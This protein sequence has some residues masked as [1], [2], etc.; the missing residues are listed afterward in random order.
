MRA[1]GL[2]IAGLAAFLIGVGGLFVASRV[3]AAPLSGTARGFGYGGMTGMSGMAG[4]M[5]GP[6]AANA[7]PIGVERA[8]TTA[9]NYVTGSGNR[10]LKLDEVMEF[11]GNYY[12]QVVEQDTGMHAFEMLVDKY[13]GAVFP[14]MGPNMVWNVKYGMMRGMMGRWSLGWSQTTS[15]PI[16]PTRA[17]DLARQYLKTQGLR[18]DVD[19]PDE[20]YGYYTLHTLRDGEIEGM[21]SVNGYSGEIWYHTW[22][23]P[24]I[25]MA[26]LQA[27]TV[28]GLR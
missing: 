22:H 13:T 16:D 10:N 19:E 18:L 26:K 1:K 3:V 7:T 15:M 11:A 9:Q 8:V 21:L 5:G 20:F 17:Q 2:F 28:D 27:R 6:A 25:Q 4:M 23:G 14:E 12:A 24:F